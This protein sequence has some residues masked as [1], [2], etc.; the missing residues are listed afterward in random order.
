MKAKDKIAIIGPYPPP[1]GG[2]SV[3]IK[4]VM[5]YMPENSYILFNS[6]K[7]NCRGSISFYGKF[8][9]IKVWR[10]LFKKYKL[11]HTHSTDTYLRLIFG[12][13][14]VF[15]KNI[16]LHIH[17][18]SLS[19][20]LKKGM[21][22]FFM[23]PLIKNL[24]IIVV[25]SELVRE[26]NKYK[27]ISIHEID[28]FLPPTFDFPLLIKTLKEY[29]RFFQNGR[30]IVSMNGW[31]TKYMG[32]DLYGF[33]LASEVLKKFRDNGINIFIV[34]CINGVKNK[35]LY[36]SFLNYITTHNL[37]KQFLLIHGLEEAWP[38]FMASNVFMRLTN[39]DGLGISIKEAIWFRTKAIASDCI[40]R[41]KGTLIFKTRSAQS[42][43]ETLL[44][45]Y[46]Q[47][48]IT[49]EEKIKQ[50]NTEVFNY[51]LFSE[52]YKFNI[53]PSA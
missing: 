11:V 52:I 13:I 25:N 7:S 20:L 18:V 16:Y 53:S 42:L 41:P 9:Y 10:F 23:K 5:K 3:H 45:I 24:N 22:S 2:I 26:I 28:A 31:F 14:G 47:P 19:N 46:R 32:E 30:F 43:Y 12:I 36:K 21:V 27:P 6:N 34:A 35:Q 44:D 40:T 15:R 29:E 51:K 38:I 49:L 33:D 39:T 50:Y 37:D 48:Q 8:K 1:Y 4:R 17:G